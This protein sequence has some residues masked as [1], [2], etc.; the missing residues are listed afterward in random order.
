MELNDTMNAPQIIL[1]LL[2][3]IGI[4]MIAA[5]HGERE[6]VTHCVWSQ[7]ICVGITWGL[8]YWGGFFS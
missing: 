4:G 2:W 5:K 7:I 1:I 3:A 6:T 8:L